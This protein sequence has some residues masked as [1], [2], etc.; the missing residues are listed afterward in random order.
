[1]AS[2]S[3]ILESFQ[4][5]KTLLFETRFQN[6][7]KDIAEVTSKLGDA[8]GK[9]TEWFDNIRDNGLLNTL[10]KEDVNELGAQFDQ[11]LDSIF[12]PSKETQI[13]MM[14]A[15]GQTPL[16]P[17]QEQARSMF[18][19][20][21]ATIHDK[22]SH[23]R[24]SSAPKVA[25]GPQPL[26]GAPAPLETAIAKLGNALP[27]P[28]G[29]ISPPDNTLDFNRRDVKPGVMIDPEPSKLPPS[30]ELGTGKGKKK[31]K[32]EEKVEPTPTPTPKKK[33]E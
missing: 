2:L 18:T 1:M 4:D 16:N 31:E 17:M 12:N 10:K 11:L 20:A 6:P 14:R 7:L 28:G 32:K 25:K 9:A 29:G 24:D 15:H 26:M 33:T 13:Q 27:G 22:L 30:I 3:S 21:V 8:L 19:E 23:F 5:I